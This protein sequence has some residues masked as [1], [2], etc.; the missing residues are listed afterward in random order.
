MIEE[1][2]IRAASW[3]PEGALSLFVSLM[4]VNYVEK[5]NAF[6]DTTSLFFCKGSKYDQSYD[7]YFLCLIFLHQKYN[8]T[9]QGWPQTP[10]AFPNETVGCNL[11]H[12]LELH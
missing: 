11:Q 2:L 9:S 4:I 6:P 5:D 8:E 3:G 12:L 7:I 10:T 1:Y